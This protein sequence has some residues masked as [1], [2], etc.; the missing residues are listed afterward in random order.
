MV[1]ATYPKEAVGSGNHW[2][3][4]PRRLLPDW[5]TR[6]QWRQRSLACADYGALGADYGALGADYGALGADHGAL[7]AHHGTVP[8]KWF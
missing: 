5:L 7:G 1:V 6:L 4:E 3:A 2:L 8:Y